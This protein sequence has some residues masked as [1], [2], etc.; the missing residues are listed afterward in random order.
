MNMV[1]LV[2]LWLVSALII[3]STSGKV[4]SNN[5]KRYYTKYSC[6]CVHICRP[7]ANIRRTH[8]SCES[9]FTFLPIMPITHRRLF[10]NLR[11]RRSM[12]ILRANN[13]I[14]TIAVQVLEDII[15]IITIS[16]WVN[17]LPA[18]R[19]PPPSTRP[20]LN[21]CVARQR[22]PSADDGCPTTVIL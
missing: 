4:A 16:S 9:G 8:E 1:Q 3:S 7:T 15:M 18:A 10:T 6:S 13:I 22:Y 20:K 17:P 14:S 2:F 21:R 5:S 19:I 11:C 12:A